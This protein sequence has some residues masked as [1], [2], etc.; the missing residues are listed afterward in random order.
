VIDDEHAH[1]T[2]KTNTGGT[3]PPH[4]LEAEEALLGSMLLSPD[5][6]RAASTAGVTLTDFYKPEHSTIY[7]A[8]ID[9]ATAGEI[10]DP[11]TVGARAPTV[12]RKRLIAIQ[13]ATPA[14][15]NAHA[16]ARVVRDLARR[17]ELIAIAYAVG[18]AAQSGTDATANVARLMVASSLV[19]TR[20]RLHNG[21]GFLFD[22]REELPAVWGT[23]DRLLWAAGESLIIG[24]PAGVGK[25][26]LTIQLVGARLGLLD[27]V[28]DFPVEPC[29]RILY[30]ACDRPA[31]IRRAF[32]RV[33]GDEHRD[34]LDEHLAFWEGPPPHD[35]ARYPDT[36][37][38]MAKDSGADCVVIDSLKDVAIGLSDDDV[39]AGLNSS[40]QQALAEG[41]DIVALH[42]QR[43]GQNGQ[44]PKTL[45][46]VYGSTWI[47]AGAGSVVLLWGAAGDPIV[48]L[49]HLK[50]PSAEVGPLKI[51][52]NH[53]T[54]R[55][56]IFRGQVDPL[57]ALRDS[58]HGITA[59][60]LA[61]R[62]T[63]KAEP[64]DNERKRAERRLDSLVERHLAHR[65]A[66]KK[67]GADGTTAARYFATT[68]DQEEPT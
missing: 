65:Q 34:H 27:H 38:S 8:I 36:L 42:H 62:E 25:T 43:K 15:A 4:D 52:H 64:T 50:Q 7:E 10:A 67:G 45:E 44:K 58:P 63:G 68:T 46:D 40:M 24:G 28:L 17:R 33:Y 12:D 14:S 37:T 29:R 2:D 19:D 9:T 60:D 35:F 23:D 1:P 13:I 41:I 39:G 61:M 31:Q 47:A 18:E 55:S 54:G 26:T 16:Y 3:K 66:A 21:G 56:S 32:R 22:E 30:L 49:L 53:N 6:I 51:E 20:Q 57:V 5:A 59:R 48:E 11:I